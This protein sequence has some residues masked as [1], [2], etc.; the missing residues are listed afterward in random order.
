MIR[1]ASRR[2]VL[3][4]GAGMSAMVVAPAVATPEERDRAIRAFAGEAQVREGR[5]SLDL[6][7][8]VEN[9]NSAPLT[10]TVESPMTEGEH[11]R[12]IA[13][14]NEANP[15]PSVIVATLGPRAGQ[16]KLSTRIRLANSQRIVAV[17][18][19]SDG[20]FWRGSAEVIVTLA[21]CVEG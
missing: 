1:S 5:V 11:V 8:L 19:L 17:A 15:Q 13:V 14:F 7:A 20:T 2:E 18:E 4:L 9:G 3:V 10:V 12:R 6:P 21:A 16:A